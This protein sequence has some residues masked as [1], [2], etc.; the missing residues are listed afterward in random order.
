MFRLLTIILATWTAGDATP[1]ARRARPAPCAACTCLRADGYRVGAIE[2]GGTVFA[3]RPVAVRDSFVVAGSVRWRTRIYTFAVDRGWAGR[4][5]GTLY[6]WSGRGGGD[7]GYVFDLGRSYLVYADEGARPAQLWT[8][9]CSD[10]APLREAGKQ[11]R[12]LR[13]YREWRPSRRR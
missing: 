7:C 3:G 1:A 8:G 13:Q 9:D 4:L 2:P 12:H 11:L 5:S 6:V 10:T